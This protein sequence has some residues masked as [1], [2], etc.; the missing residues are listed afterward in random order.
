VAEYERKKARLQELEQLGMQNT[1]QRQ[2]IDW[3]K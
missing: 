3:R 2:D 1:V